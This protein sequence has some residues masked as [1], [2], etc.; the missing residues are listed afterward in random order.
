MRIA[1]LNDFIVDEARLARLRALG[2]LICCPDTIEESTARARL[3]DVDI[4]VIDGFKLPVPRAL[5]EAGEDLRLVVLT[6]TA[7]HMVDLTAATER[8]VAIAN[9]PGYSTQAVAE[10]AIAL[11]FAV[12]RTI[13]R[14]DR[15]MRTQPF[16]IDPGNKAHHAFLGWELRGK[17]LGVVGL[18][19]IGRGVAELG[20]GRSDDRREGQEGPSK[21]KYSWI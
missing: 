19:A 3:K 12:A 5:F 9:I 4:A 14:A 13:P 10:H 21:C 18:G 7:F 1:I 15:A 16:Q 2:A 17:T 8:G 11:L 6:S 20:L